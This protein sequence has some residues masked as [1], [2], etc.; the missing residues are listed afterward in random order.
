MQGVLSVLLATFTGFGVTMCGNSI[1]V[2]ALKWRRELRARANQQQGPVETR[3]M[4]Q[5]PAIPQQTQTTNPNR[6]E[7]HQGGDSDAVRAN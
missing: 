1:L 6:D 7:N 5:P 2:E 3:E 4:D